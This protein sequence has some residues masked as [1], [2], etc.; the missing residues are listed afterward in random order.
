[1]PRPP[2]AEGEALGPSAES[3]TLLSWTLGLFA[4]TFGGLFFVA[5]YIM[6]EVEPGFPATE[7]VEVQPDGTFQITIG[8]R[9][10][11]KWVGLDMGAGTVVPEGTPADVRFRR[12]V[13]R[14]PGGAAA[15][16][17]TPLNFEEPP[18]S[19]EWKFDVNVDGGLQNP[20]VARWYEYGLQSHLLTTKGET[21]LIQRSTGKGKAAFQIVS[22]YCEP[23]GSGCL[24]IR[25]R[26][27]N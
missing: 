5:S 15:L 7:K 6:P 22:Y 4:L 20:A 16:G 14:V 2:E 9:D 23:E 8:V 17:E 19:V 26:L 11:D 18:Q 21:Y 24:T 25:Y 13:V 1:M 27:L 10:R 12:Y 3:K